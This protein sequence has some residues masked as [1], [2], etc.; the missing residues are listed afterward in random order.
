[1]NNMIKPLC[2]WVVKGA[3]KSTDYPLP[4]LAR[5]YTCDTAVNYYF[6]V[7]LQKL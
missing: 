7:K 3:R 5:R 1:M 2:I 6:N 4:T